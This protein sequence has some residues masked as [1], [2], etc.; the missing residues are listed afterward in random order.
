M[1]AHPRP[2]Q[3]LCDNED[4]LMLS[5]RQGSKDAFRIVHDK[6][7][8][9]LLYFADNIIN[10][11]P[12]AEDIVSNAF[13]KLFHAREE[14]RTFE[15]V[16]RWLY[17]IVRN[18]AIDY[19]RA[20]SKWRESREDIAYLGS[21]SEEHIETERVRSIL[22]QEINNEIDKLP[23][24]RRTIIHLYFFGQKSTSEIAGLLQLSPQTVLNHKTKALEMLRKNNHRLRRIVEDIPGFLL[25]AAFFL[26]N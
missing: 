4:A 9:Q 24:Q 8:K 13:L 26:M 17:V 21:D 19:L 18:E 12:D 22:L 25:V 16:K 6:I 1:H 3:M 23:R 7:V 5:F 20:K 15:H 2:E 11:V 10:S 14:M